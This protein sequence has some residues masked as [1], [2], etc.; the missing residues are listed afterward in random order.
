MSPVTTPNTSG[1]ANLIQSLSSSD[2]PLAAIGLSSSQIQSALQHASPNDV[3]QL[4][5]Q[6][7]QLQE[8]S[9]MFGSPDTSQSGGLF[10]SPATTSSS[11]TIFN[12]LL[13]TLDST[14]ALATPTPSAASSQSATS[15]TLAS[16]VATAQNQMRSET[17]QSLFGT[18]ST[19][20]ASG[21]L[22]NTLV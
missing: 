14:S 15:S 4:S 6:A 19:T 16:E 10:P 20:G 13:A 8:V 3:A 1:M 21:T 7:L 12:N 17:L 18:D 11:D 2:S 9:V 22:L 5:V